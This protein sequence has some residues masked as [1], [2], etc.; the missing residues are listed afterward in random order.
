MLT[1]PSVERQFETPEQW[2]PENVSEQLVPF[3]D[4]REPVA[5]GMLLGY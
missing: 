5:D 4:G 3:Y 1:G 2:T